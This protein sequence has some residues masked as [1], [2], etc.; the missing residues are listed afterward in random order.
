MSVEDGLHD[1]DSADLAHVMYML[2]GSPSSTFSS[3]VN[4]LIISFP[5]HGHL[6]AP[7][8]TTTKIV[9]LIIYKEQYY[10]M[11]VNLSI[12]VDDLC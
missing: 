11:K 8:S 5:H 9:D 4:N 6:R 12:D 10:S 1:A 7:Q 3:K 2:Q